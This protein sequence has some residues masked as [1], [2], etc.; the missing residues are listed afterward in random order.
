MSSA[1]GELPSYPRHSPQAGLGRSDA[2]AWSSFLICAQTAFLWGACLLASIDLGAKPT[3]RCGRKRRQD[4]AVCCG[5]D[6]RCECHR[7]ARCPG[8]EASTRPSPPPP[9]DI[10]SGWPVVTPGRRAGSSRRACGASSTSRRPGNVYNDIVVSGWT[11]C[12]PENVYVDVVGWGPSRVDMNF[13]EF[14]NI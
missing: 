2:T 3:M 8:P 4:R 6:G 14:F 1:E 13:A 10:F 5:G 12:R 9:F 11:S 7:C